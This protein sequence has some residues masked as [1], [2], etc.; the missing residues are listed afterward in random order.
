MEEIKTIQCSIQEYNIY[1]EK[2]LQELVSSEQ[3]AV[4]DQVCLWKIIIKINDIWISFKVMGKFDEILINCNK[5]INHL[6]KLASKYKSPLENI[7]DQNVPKQPQIGAPVPVTHR[8]LL[9]KAYTIPKVS[10]FMYAFFYLLIPNM[11]ENTR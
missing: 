5:K 8:S 11:N 3:K 10:R 6:N 2:S 9:K 4:I 1:F 7:S